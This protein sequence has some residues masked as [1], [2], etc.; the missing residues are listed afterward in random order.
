MAII[1]LSGRIGS[2][3]DTAAAIIQQIAPYHN[4]QVKKFAGKLK[5]I[6]SILTGIPVEKFE[7]QD[8]KK[9]FLSSEWDTVKLVGS[10]L[11]QDGFDGVKTPVINSMSVRDLLQKLGTEAIR[12][13]LHKDVWV[14][15]LFS[16]YRPLNDESRV[17]MGNVLDYSN[18]KFPNWIITDTRFENELH[19]VKA[20]QGIT[21]KIVCDSNNEIV[22]QHSS[23][24]AL[25]HVKD[26][27]YIINNVGAVEELKQKLYEILLKESLIQSPVL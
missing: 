25:D 22:N 27:D 10:G 1:S 18:C 24:N 11:R 6:A 23:E 17:S 16:E 19:A 26:W 5:Q 8:F 7:S 21:I 2:G 12:D 20:R 3:K 9:T 13:G 15:A 14:N 4:W